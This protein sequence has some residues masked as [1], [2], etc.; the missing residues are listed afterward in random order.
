M[1][2]GDIPI[3]H[4]KLKYLRMSRAVDKNKNVL[5]IYKPGPQTVFMAQNIEKGK[6]NFSTNH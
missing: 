5:K 3:T 2:L 4:L 6:A 1:T